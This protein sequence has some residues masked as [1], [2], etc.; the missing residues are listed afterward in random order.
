MFGRKKN[1]KTFSSFEEHVLD[2]AQRN[3]SVS[4]FS[5]EMEMQAKIQAQK[6]IEIKAILLQDQMRAELQNNEDEQE[7]KAIDGG[8][9]RTFI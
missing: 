9:G 6:K 8:L 7:E 4:K 5:K 2:A 1:P 3:I